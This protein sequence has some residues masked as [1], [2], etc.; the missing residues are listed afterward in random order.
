MARIL[1]VEDSHSQMAS[2]KRLVESMGHLPICA[3]SADEALAW[4][5]EVVSGSIQTTALGSHKPDLILMDVLM[6]GSNGYQAT[7][8]LTRDPRTSSIPIIMM[9]TKAEPPDQI[10]GIKQGASAYLAKPIADED[11]ISAIQTHLNMAHENKA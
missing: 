1:I 5:E 2:F 3:V 6:P 11:L 4:M 7:R 8:R 10:W 9:S